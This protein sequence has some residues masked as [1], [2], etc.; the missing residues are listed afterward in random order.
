[1]KRLDLETWNALADRHKSQAEEWTRP[2]RQ[3]SATGQIHP[4]HDFLFIY[5]LSLIHI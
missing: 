3:R 4:V 1:M 5:Y 2:Y